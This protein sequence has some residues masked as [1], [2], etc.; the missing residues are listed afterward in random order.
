MLVDKKF[1]YISLPRCA[2]TAFYYSC[3]IQNID[4][5]H[6]M[7]KWVNHNSKIDF[8]N[9]PTKDL[10]NYIEHGHEKLSDLENKF[11]KRYPI[12]SVK[13][14]RYSRFYSLYKHMLFDL[15]RIGA[16]SV[17]HHFKFLSTKDLFFFNTKDIETKKSRWNLI[18][19]YL[20]EYGLNNDD[21]IINIID[22]FI[23]P[24]SFW[25]NND[26][27]I[28][29]FEFGE[30]NKMEK[31]ISDILNIDFKMYNVNSSSHIDSDIIMNDTFIKYY[32]SIY[33]FYD[34]PKLKNT[35]I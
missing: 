24:Q 30:F 31:W 34:F 25:H 35:L 1:I 8:K 20:I 2:S 9:V 11:G 4:V 28:I 13:R 26:S 19:N 12:I 22:I 18:N 15:K 21:Y 29:W 16:D 6:T 17:Y 23:T 5:K 7:N 27:R 3:L 10:M 33:N 32:D 14:D